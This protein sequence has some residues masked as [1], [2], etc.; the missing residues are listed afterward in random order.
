M[1]HR[2][3]NAG[4]EIGKIVSV[5][6][7]HPPLLQWEFQ[8]ECST[9]GCR[10]CLGNGH[11]SEGRRH[12]PRGQGKTQAFRRSSCVPFFT[13]LAVPEKLSIGKGLSYTVRSRSSK[14]SA[15]A[16]A[17]PRAVLS[18]MHQIGVEPAS[19]TNRPARASRYSAG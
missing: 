17:A 1:A 11:E 18:K 19:Q 2:N 8:G 6:P 4:Q 14:A 7:G 13:F 12:H 5:P 15:L 16:V 3:G 10:S 9:G